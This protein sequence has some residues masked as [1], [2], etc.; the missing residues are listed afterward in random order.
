MN[1]PQTFLLAVSLSVVLTGCG[2]QAATSESQPTASPIKT[3]AVSESGYKRRLAEDLPAVGDPLPPLDD[4]RVEIAGPEGWRP[5][6]R[7]SKY[8][9]AFIKEGGRQL[10]RIVATV[11]DPPADVLDDTAEDNAHVLAEVLDAGLRQDDT[12]VVPEH[13]VPIIL[14][15]RTFVRHVRLATMGG[16][17]VV[18]Q[19]LQTV[20]GGRLY[21]VELICAV[22]AADGREYVQSLKT[23]RDDGYSVAANMKFTAAEPGPA[24]ATSETP[25]AEN[26]T[27]PAEV[28]Q[29]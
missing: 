8:L 11:G 22:N 4:G 23:Y 12:K 21:T 26:P 2:E 9:A 15:E 5:L 7:N 6:L 10:P 17:P 18:I 25:P 27:K 3:Q 16:D 19:S 24:D 20:A 1:P 13:C 14:G 29:P 28:A